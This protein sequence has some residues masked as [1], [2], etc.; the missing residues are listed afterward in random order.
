MIRPTLLAALLAWAPAACATEQPPVGAA[1]ARYLDW[2]G[3]AEVRLLPRG[4]SKGWLVGG[5]SGLAWDGRQKRLIAV[6]DRGQVFRLPV[7]ADDAPLHIAR[8]N[9]PRRLRDAEAIRYAAQH[10]WYV[11][12]E[13]EN[14]IA[15]YPGDAERMSNRPARMITLGGKDDQGENA[16]VEALALLDFGRLLAIAE[17]G[18]GDGDRRKAWVVDGETIIER[19][20]AVPDGFSP[21]DAVGLP[22]GD[23]LMLERRFNGLP[24]PFFSSRLALI[25]AA[26]LDGEGPIPISTR[27][28]LANVLPSE[29][30]EGMEIVD[31]A[32]GPDLW[33][34]SDDN[35]QWPQNTLLA[36]IPLAFLLERLQDRRSQPK[37]RFQ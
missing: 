28:D 25:E 21:V 6:A 36:R 9:A 27:L 26:A 30:W 16:G 23:L 10:G 31:G 32:D 5:L 13:E 22:S 18:D 7:S 34:V 20:I 3:Q 33:V 2:E 8:L 1:N 14:V 17:G 11:A 15:Y 19:A 29:N 24:P 37:A 12:L 35:M 4:R